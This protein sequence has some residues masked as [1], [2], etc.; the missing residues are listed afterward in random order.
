LKRRLRLNSTFKQICFK[1]VRWS[2]WRWTRNDS[3]SKE[4][5]KKAFDHLVRK[6]KQEKKIFVCFKSFIHSFIIITSPPSNTLISNHPPP[7]TGLTT[8][9]GFSGTGQLSTGLDLS[10]QKWLLGIDCVLV[11]NSRLSSRIFCFVSDLA[12]FSLMQ[13]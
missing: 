10:F 6:I 13:L 11:T 7:I 5:E 3:K 12:I 4:R 2:F 9:L 8:Q 1:T